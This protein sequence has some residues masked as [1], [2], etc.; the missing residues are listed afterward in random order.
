MVPTVGL[1]DNGMGMPVAL[2]PRMYQCIV[3]AT[4]AHRILL[5]F[6][7][8]TAVYRKVVYACYFLFVNR[9]IE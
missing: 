3:Y 4:N 8:S 7:L 5:C 9:V 1:A 6:F 2:A